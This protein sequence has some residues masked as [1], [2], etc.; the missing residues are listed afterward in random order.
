MI[1]E[2]NLSN[3]SNPQISVSNTNVVL[4]ISKL[5]KQTVPNFKTYVV[6]DFYKKEN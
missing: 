3:I 1:A 5:M 2:E 6:S 4:L